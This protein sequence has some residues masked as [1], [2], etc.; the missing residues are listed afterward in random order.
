MCKHRGYSY[1]RKYK[2]DWKRDQ[3]TKQTLWHQTFRAHT[4]LPVH[5]HLIS[6]GCSRSACA[7][8]CLQMHL[9]CPHLKFQAKRPR[10][11]LPWKT[12]ENIA[13]CTQLKHFPFSKRAETRSAG[14]R[15]SEALRG[16]WRVQEVAMFSLSTLPLCP[17]PAACPGAFKQP[18]SLTR[19]GLFL[20]I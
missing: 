18:K 6:C 9:L 5:A 17:P 7:N 3:S 14:P 19:D 15:A 11:Y 4:H 2:H 1:K 8:T 20:S 10:H 12:L 13:R 16:S